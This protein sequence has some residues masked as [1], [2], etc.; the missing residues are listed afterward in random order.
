MRCDL[1]KHDSRTTKANLGLSLAFFTR[2]SF[3]RHIGMLRAGASDQ[4]PWKVGLQSAL[5][6]LGFGSPDTASTVDNGFVHIRKFLANVLN[7][8]GRAAER[9]GKANDAFLIA[10]R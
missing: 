3:E 2:P 9:L 7:S 6:A 10:I 1:S 5:N 4:N 8:S